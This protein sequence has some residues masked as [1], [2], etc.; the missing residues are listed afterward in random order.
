MFK[1]YSGSFLHQN[2]GYAIQNLLCCFVTFLL[3]TETKSNE[4][5]QIMSSYYRIVFFFPSRFNLMTVTNYFN[6]HKTF[7]F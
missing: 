2:L 3:K 4:Q 7:K 1:K 5:R 6:S